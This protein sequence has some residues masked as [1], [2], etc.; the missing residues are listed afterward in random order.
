M[1]YVVGADQKQ[2]GPISEETLRGWIREGRV[3]P[4]SLSLKEGEAQWSPMAGREEFQ[5][6]LAAQVRAATADSAPPRPTQQVPVDPS[7]PKE[8]LV[9]LLLSIFLGYFA[10]D[11]FYLGHVGLGILKL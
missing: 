3:G 2:Y 9:A 1:F 5:E 8:W 10:V 7:T 11:R 4:P 6:A